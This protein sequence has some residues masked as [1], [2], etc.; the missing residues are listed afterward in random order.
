MN[1]PMPKFPVVTS[2]DIIA[3][4][5]AIRTREDASANG[6]TVAEIAAIVQTDCVGFNDLLPSVS[7]TIIQLHRRE[8]ADLRAKLHEAVGA[9]G[10]VNVEL[11]W[12]R[13]TVSIQHR[14]KVELTHHLAIARDQLDRIAAMAGVPLAETNTFAAI[15]ERL[16][17]LG[18]KPVEP[19][20]EQAAANPD[21]GLAAQ[22]AA[23]AG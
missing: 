21:E 11:G 22:E 15:M 10:G 1:P 13:H 3:V 17:E 18:L 6:L 19:A 16:A 9:L 4:A 5:E 20:A 23:A 14:D 12:K 8:V 7:K 2:P